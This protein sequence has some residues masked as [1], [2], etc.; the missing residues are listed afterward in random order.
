M[1]N[2]CVHHSGS[3]SVVH[4]QYRRPQPAWTVSPASF[5]VLS[6]IH[7]NIGPSAPA[8]DPVF[9]TAVT[10]RCVLN[11]ILTGVQEL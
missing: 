8:E 2:R 7:D 1:T 6:G 9:P 4:S 5:L 11:A 10:Q 3:F